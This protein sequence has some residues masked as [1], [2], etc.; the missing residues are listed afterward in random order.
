M[1]AGPKENTLITSALCMTDKFLL[2][3]ADPP[4]LELYSFLQQ[5]RLIDSYKIPGP[6]TSLTWGAK[7]GSILVAVGEAALL[8]EVDSSLKLVQKNQ[9]NIPQSHSL[10]VLSYSNSLIGTAGE[11]GVLQV[12]K[13]QGNTYSKVL[14]ESLHTAPVT[15]LDFSPDED[16]VATSSLDRSCK[17][18]SLKESKL[19]KNLVFS[20]HEDSPD[21]AF[22]G[23]K[24]SRSGD[25]LYTVACDTYT[26]VTQWDVLSEMRP[27]SSHLI[28]ASPTTCFSISQDGFFLGIG[29]EDGWVKTLNTRTMEL[30]RDS[31]DLSS[32]VKS[33][34]FTQESRH[35]I[36][37]ADNQFECIFHGRSEGLFSKA[38]K[39]WVVCLFLLWLYLYLKNSSP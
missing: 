6:A 26:F 21:L 17:V 38:S 22:Q 30:E 18:F 35:I 8:L 13:Q 10:A 14:S 23:V 39:I 19:I 24:F 25:I 37:V 3:R 36:A 2:S 28:H 11:N 12:W 32:A 16:L 15:G 5:E 7:T 20:Q 27:I 1:A 31:E 9:I 29:T 33:I 4:L 34:S